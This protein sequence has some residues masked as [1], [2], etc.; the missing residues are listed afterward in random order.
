M[1]YRT[2]VTGSYSVCGVPVGI[3]GIDVQVLLE[4]M[5]LAVE[6]KERSVADDIFTR[7]ALSLAETA[8]I[9]VGQVLSG[10]EME[11]LIGDLFA[12]ATPKLHTRW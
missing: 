5:F 11:R 10:E 3:E 6:S 1:I 12:I 9:P 2:W 4:Q 7:L 8:A